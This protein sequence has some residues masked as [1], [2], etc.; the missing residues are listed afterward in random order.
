MR[1]LYY[2]GTRVLFS[3]KNGI[4]ELSPDDFTTNKL[5]DISAVQLC[6]NGSDI[7]FSK[8]NVIYRL[9]SDDPIYNEVFTRFALTDNGILVVQNIDYSC[10]MLEL[11]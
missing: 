10:K 9:G 1:T 3:D 6:S 5:S 11:S 2:D 7:F 8:D 4:Y